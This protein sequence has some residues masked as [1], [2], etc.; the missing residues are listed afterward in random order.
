[1]KAYELLH[2]YML[3]IE[4]PEDEELFPPEFVE[5]REGNAEIN[6]SPAHCFEGKEIRYE[7]PSVEVTNV[8]DAENPWNILVGDDWNLVLKAAA[9]KIFLEYK[10]VFAWTYKDLKGV[11][12]EMCVHRI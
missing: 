12:L 4:E 3:G 5:Y 9:F 6:E 8:G 1:M 10:D 11:L 2:T 7:E